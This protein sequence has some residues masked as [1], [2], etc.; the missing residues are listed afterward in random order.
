[1]PTA[2][3]RNNNL[4][5]IPQQNSLINISIGKK[6]NLAQRRFPS[7]AVMRPLQEPQQYFRRQSA[8]KITLQDVKGSSPD[9]KPIKRNILHKGFQNLPQTSLS[10]SP[11]SLKKQQ[12]SNK[13]PG[14]YVRAMT[15]SQFRGK[16]LREFSTQRS[17]V[18]F[19][20]QPIKKDS[21]PKSK[22][23]NNLPFKL[24][25]LNDQN[26]LIKRPKGKKSSFIN[27]SQKPYKNED[28][29]TG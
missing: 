1:M 15:T 12:G 24:S 8:F 23:E 4:S 6:S 22:K 10:N 17:G 11:D 26:I 9:I 18:V 20:Q 27:F 25:N 2:R 29:H 16:S 7:F 13:K 21:P 5:I 28:C 3:S 19:Q 14:P